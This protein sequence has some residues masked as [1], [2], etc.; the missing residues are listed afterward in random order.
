MQTVLPSGCTSMIWFH[1]ASSSERAM[2]AVGLV[3]AVRSVIAI[4]DHARRGGSRVASGPCGTG[5]EK[6][7]VA[8]TGARR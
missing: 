4:G 8:D 7:M 6:P 1:N 2:P 3:A 5:P